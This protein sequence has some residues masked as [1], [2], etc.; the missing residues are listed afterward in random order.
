MTD[1]LPPMFCDRCPDAVGVD[2]CGPGPGHCL[3][4]STGP[5]EIPTGQPAGSPA[6]VGSRP[7]GPLP[8]LLWG[9]ARSEC[10][11]LTGDSDTESCWEER[12]AIVAALRA[13]QAARDRAVR[14]ATE[15]ERLRG[16]VAAAAALLRDYHEDESVRGAGRDER[17][18]AWL[19]R[20]QQPGMTGDERAALADADQV[21]RLRAEVLVLAARATEAEGERDGYRGEVERLRRERDEL[22]RVLAVR[23]A[24]I[25][26]GVQD[27]AEEIGT[28]RQEIARLRA[29]GGPGGPGGAPGGAA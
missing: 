8:D 29:V 5:T 6:P 1:T 12:E 7:G 16:E 14:Q 4:C 20:Q 28:L 21:E 10:A 22:R 27:V 17:T 3:A 19:A 15:D 25:V 13:S 11:A 23:D 26:E 2:A 9:P 24:E 18:A